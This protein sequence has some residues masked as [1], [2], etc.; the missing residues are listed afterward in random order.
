MPRT[1]TLSSYRELVGRYLG[2]QTRIVVAMSG[3][4]I[5]ATGLQLAAPLVVGRLID[6]AEAGVSDT[7]L[8]RTAVLFL[9]LAL[10]AQAVALL[11][12]LFSERVAWQA[13]NALRLDLTRHLLRLGPGFH[14]RHPAGALIERVDGDVSLLNSLLSSVATELFSSALLLFGLIAVLFALDGWLGLCFG[15]LVALTTVLLESIRRRSV[16]P[17]ERSREHSA[18]FFG[19]VGEI[20]AATEDLRPN[21]GGPYVLE[22]LR[23][24]WADWFPTYVKAELGAYRVWIVALIAFGVGD[25]IAYGFGAGL[26]L[27]HVLTLG[28]VYVVVAYAALVASPLGTIRERLVE[29]QGADAAIWRIGELLEVE[30]AVVGGGGPVP[31]GPLGVRFDSVYFA[32]PDSETCVSGGQ[33]HALRGVSFQVAPGRRLG[34]IGRS[35]SGKTTLARLL[36]RLY[37]PQAGAVRLE[38]LSLPSL[39]LASLRSRVRYVT[40][41]VQIFSASLRDNLTLFADRADDYYLISLL[42]SL[43]LDGWLREQPAGLDTLIGPGLMSAGE[44]QLIAFARAFDQDPGLVILDEA[45]SQLDPATEAVLEAAATRLLFGRTGIVI[46]HRPA[47]LERMDDILVL[48]H[49]RVVEAGERERLTADPHSLYQSF[50][51]G[52]FGDVLA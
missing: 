2:P 47:T 28:Q 51:R 1:V 6:Q 4:L 42:A 9:V 5:T 16:P 33:V 44:A 49:G 46:A 25:G 19:F 37:D 52:G 29:L 24:L 30:P 14:G 8:V 32:Y 11:A 41:D 15:G 10:L 17:E 48:E 13:T 18:R 23:R 38:G 7:V 50:R 39:S 12:A 34:V 45:S 26:Y 27:S 3:C 31:E 36:V 40:Q 35:G 21:G 22:R 43:G 20:L